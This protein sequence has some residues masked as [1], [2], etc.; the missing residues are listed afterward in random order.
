MTFIIVLFILLIK[1]WLRVAGPREPAV[2]PAPQRCHLPR[3]GTPQLCLGWGG[4]TGPQGEA[5]EP[6]AH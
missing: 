4:R 5:R 1:R 6:F 3:G 2:E